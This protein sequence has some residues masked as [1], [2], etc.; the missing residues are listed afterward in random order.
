MGYI[1]SLFGYVLNFL[2]NLVNNYGIAIILFSILLRIILLPIT[3][4]QQKTMIKTTKLQSKM[5]EI[6]FKYKNNPERL[7]QETMN[8]YKQENLSP[9]SGCFSMIIQFIVILS[10]FYMVSSPLTYMK[11]IDKSVIDEYKSKIS[12]EGNTNSAYQEI[13]IIN[14]YSNEDEQLKINM[15]F[16]GIDLSMVPKD[17]LNDFKVYIIPGLYVI[18]SF[19]SIRIT[20]KKQSKMQNKLLEAGNKENESNE[21]DT[22]Q[23]M[24]KNMN[25]MMP[26]ISI[27]IALVAPLG[28]ALYWLISNILMTAERIVIEKVVKE[29]EA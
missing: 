8:L 28:L 14:R 7:N 10:V 21:I 19:I 11:K 23:Q 22:M 13:A 2:Y 9:F 1:A 27:S 16:L 12:A 15:G 5:K 18:S 26:I 29:E 17:H 4:K 3:I 24:N 25:Y 6:Q 20:T